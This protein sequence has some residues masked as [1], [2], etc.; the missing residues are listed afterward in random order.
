MTTLNNS[1]ILGLYYFFIKSSSAFSGA[2]R[3]CRSS[4]TFPAPE[5]NFSDGTEVGGL[6]KYFW[7]IC[8]SFGNL[9]KFSD[10]H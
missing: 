9:V 1:V 5:N 6:L 10:H 8:V 4:Y 7:A 3:L 2:R